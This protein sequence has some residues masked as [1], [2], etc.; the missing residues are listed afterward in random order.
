MRTPKEDTGTRIRN[1]LVLP[2]TVLQLLIEGKK[3]S[4]K[5]AKE[6]LDS[7]N[8]AVELTKK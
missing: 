5:D 7:L 4:Q 2:S 1:A 8:E 6:A 3:V